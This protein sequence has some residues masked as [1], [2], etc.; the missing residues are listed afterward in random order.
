[1]LWLVA[2]YAGGLVLAGAAIG[3]PAA[4]ALS[5]FVKTFLYGIGAQDAVAIAGATV[6]LMA[7][8]AVAAF[9]P[10]AA[11]DECGPDRGATARIKVQ[12]RISNSTPPTI[13][14]PGIATPRISWYDVLVTFATCT[15][16]WT[17]AFRARGVDVPHGVRIARLPHEHAQ[18]R[19]ARRCRT[20]SVPCQLATPECV[21]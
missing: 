3:I 8:A 5:R 15:N 4:L 18:P 14:R 2:R 16:G 19:A 20:G 12:R 6:T 11:R 9:L 1:M 17:R 7:A 13:V 21:G 10:R